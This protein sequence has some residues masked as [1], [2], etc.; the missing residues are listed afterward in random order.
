VICT[1]G[2]VVV[3]TAAGDKAR[4]AR[5]ESIFLGPEDSRAV[6]LGLGE[7][8]QAYVPQSRAMHSRLVDVV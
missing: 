2:E 7:I 4:L 1:G 8:V 3:R 6:V 5:G